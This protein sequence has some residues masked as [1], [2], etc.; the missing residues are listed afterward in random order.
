M[1][2]GSFPRDDAHAVT[3]VLANRERRTITVIPPDTPHF[4]ASEVLDRVAGGDEALSPVA[5]DE[6]AKTVWQTEE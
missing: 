5:E 1:K 6:W 4:E 2:T 3:L